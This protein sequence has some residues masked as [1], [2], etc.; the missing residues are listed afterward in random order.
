V[1]LIL[2]DN[3]VF[4]SSELLLLDVGLSFSHEAHRKNKPQNRRN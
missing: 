1:F 2:A 3:F 4:T